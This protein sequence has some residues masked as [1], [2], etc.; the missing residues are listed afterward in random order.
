MSIPEDRR[1]VK[2]MP[3][4]KGQ[5]I[6]CYTRSGSKLLFTEFGI[7]AIV[8]CANPF[9]DEEVSVILPKS[10][11]RFRRCVGDGFQYVRDHR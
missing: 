3:I 8:L 9:H 5:S 4:R 11:S 10:E 2:G 6:F 7:L 1:S